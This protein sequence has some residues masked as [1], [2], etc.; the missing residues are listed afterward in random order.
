MNQIEIRLNDNLVKKGLGFY[1][2]DSKKDIK[3][4]AGETLVLDQTPFVNS[5]IQSGEILVVNANPTVTK[6]KA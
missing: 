6:A 3:H 5:K 2:T 1:D 4:K